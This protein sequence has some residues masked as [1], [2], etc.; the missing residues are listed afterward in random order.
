M[1]RNEKIKVIQSRHTEGIFSTEEFVEK[2]K[3]GV[4]FFVVDAS[5]VYYV[6]KGPFEF[7]S[8]LESVKISG[9]LSR[10]FKAKVVPNESRTTFDSYSSGAFVNDLFWGGKACFLVEENAKSYGSDLQNNYPEHEA[11]V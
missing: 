8:F 1:S 3:E 6:V 4:K 5:E 2:M 9:K 10:C 7:I 11:L